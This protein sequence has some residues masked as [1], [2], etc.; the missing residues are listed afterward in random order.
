VDIMSMGT[1]HESQ[2]TAEE[3]LES[4]G[5]HRSDHQQWSVQCS[6]SHHLASVYRT[7]AGLVHRAVA[8][9]HAHGSKDR[10]DTAHH[11][12]TRGTECMDLLVG[13]AM[14]Y[15]GLPAWCDCGTHTLSRAGLI[16]EATAGRHTV[17]VE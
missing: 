14:S 16:E 1:S 7:P 8:G 9:E 3:A 17:R 5:I 10:I 13:N 12:S 11:S 4:L 15:D 6:R 2:S